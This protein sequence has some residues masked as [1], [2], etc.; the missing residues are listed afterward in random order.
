MLRREII[1]AQKRNNPGFS[2]NDSLFYLDGLSVDFNGKLALDSIQLKVERGEILFVTGP[3]GAGKTTLL[4]VLSGDLKPTE[5]RLLTPDP[6]RHFCTTVYQDLKLEPSLSCEANL[7]IAYDPSIYKNK[8][9][10]EKEVSELT[11]YFSIEDSLG[12]KIKDCNGGL[13]QKI[14]IIRALLSRPDILLAD[15]PTSSLDQRNSEKLFEVLSYYNSKR[16]MTVIWASHNRNLV[17]QFSGRI[18]HMDN[19]KMIYSGHAC[20]I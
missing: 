11:S 8:K 13:K 19:G 10:F 3:S 14:A 16:K 4:K 15:E 18:V 9:E 1:S 20:F 17:G 6:S 7:S 5:G 12:L 2:S